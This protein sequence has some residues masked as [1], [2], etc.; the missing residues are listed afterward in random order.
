MEGEPSIISG[1]KLIILKKFDLTMFNPGLFWFISI[2][3]IILPMKWS[4]LYQREGWI[5]NLVWLISLSAACAVLRYS[6]MRK[7]SRWQIPSIWD[8][9]GSYRILPGCPY[10]WPSMALYNLVEK[11]SILNRML[12]VRVVPDYGGDDRFCFNDL[13]SGISSDRTI[14]SPSK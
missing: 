1:L 6:F 10:S 2:L 14:S 13:G 8:W 4:V 3:S 7:G 11:C 12:N 9:I 5:K